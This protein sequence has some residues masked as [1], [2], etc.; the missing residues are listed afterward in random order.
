[1]R[2]GF[3]SFFLSFIMVF[4]A[5]GPAEAI[6][7]QVP[8]KDVQG[9]RDSALVARFAGSVIVGYQVV[10]GGKLILPMG[11]FET[12]EISDTQTARG[13]VTRIAYVAP[14]GKS[15]QDVFNSFQGVLKQAGFDEY[16][17]CH[18]DEGRHSCGGGYSMA[19]AITDPVLAGLAGGQQ[20]L[21]IATLNPA[22]DNAYMETAHLARPDGNVDI[23][24][25]VSQE[26]NQPTGILLQVCEAGPQSKP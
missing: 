20:A 14:Q 5:I 25:L 12:Q 7:V 16:F 23:V 8:D 6:T 22:N 26:D 9:S 15:A 19:S 13:K 2:T 10:D 17:S 11:R 21:M 1:V 3:Y 18:G 4:A 24:L